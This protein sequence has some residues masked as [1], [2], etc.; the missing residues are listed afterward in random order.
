MTNSGVGSEEANRMRSQNM[1]TGD[2]LAASYGC[3]ESQDIRKK[4]NWASYEVT[5]NYQQ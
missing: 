2:K 5:E 1:N 3:S 4:D